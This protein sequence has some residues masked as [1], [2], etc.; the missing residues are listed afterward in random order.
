MAK[1]TGY[2]QDV[3]RRVA[4]AERMYIEGVTVQ[5]GKVSFHSAT[6]LSLNG[7]SF[8]SRNTLIATGARPVIPDVAGLEET[9]FL[10]NEDVF[11]LMNL[12]LSFIIVGGGGR[13]AWS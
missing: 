2:V 9:G 7:E 1:V 13:L 8:T 12:P 3:I 5:F 4:K 6:M 10:T 11:D